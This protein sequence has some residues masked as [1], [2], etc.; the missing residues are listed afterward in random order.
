[1][2]RVVVPSDWARLACAS[3]VSNPERIIAMPAVAA[4]ATA[5]AAAIFT[6]VENAASRALAISASFDMR[7]K[8]VTPALPTPSNSA[9]TCLPPTAA[10]RTETR[11]S[12][13][14]QFP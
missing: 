3:M 5:T 4:A 1:M 6:R 10:R 8:P 9:R 11:F 2:L 7:P 13:I 14:D 12:V